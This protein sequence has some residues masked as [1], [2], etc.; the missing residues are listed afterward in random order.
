MGKAQNFLTAPRKIKHENIFAN[1]LQMFYFT[2]NRG[3]SQPQWCQAVLLRSTVPATSV[4]E[5]T[6]VYTRW[7]T[8]DIY[9]MQPSNDIVNYLT[10]L[11]QYYNSKKSDN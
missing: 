9:Q 2:R 5:L 10:L 3:P 6:C 4:L 11:T 7:T 8:Q 1:V